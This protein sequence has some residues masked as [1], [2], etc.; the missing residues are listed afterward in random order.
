MKHKEELTDAIEF[1]LLTKHRKIYSTTRRSDIKKWVDENYEVD[2]Y[3]LKK[4]NEK[5]PSFWF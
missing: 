5:T 2:N 1:Y 3:E 4:K